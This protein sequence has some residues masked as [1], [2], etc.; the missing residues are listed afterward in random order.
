MFIASF[1]DHN[2]KSWRGEAL[3]PKEYFP[4]NVDKFNIYGIHGTEQNGGRFYEALFPVP[5]P[6]PDFHRIQHFGDIKL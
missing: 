3:V 4:E 2:E 5:G 1:S 6:H